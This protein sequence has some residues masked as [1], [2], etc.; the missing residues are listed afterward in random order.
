MSDATPRPALSITLSTGEEIK[1]VYGLEMDLRRMLP[2]P[3]SAMQL[4]MSDA[5]TQ[6]YIVRRCLTPV[7]KMVLQQEE[8]IG[9]DNVEITSEDVEA[10]LRWVVEHTL[11]FFMK[12][13]T[14][15][16]EVA[17][18]FKMDQ[19]P[20]ST[21]GSEGSPSSTPSAGPSTA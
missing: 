21:T 19:T 7:K 12:R 9:F 3:Q 1:M 18:M 6:D 16:A 14:A 15:M 2:D 13:A 10:L 5:F 20:P 11:Y 8:L 4:V 17:S